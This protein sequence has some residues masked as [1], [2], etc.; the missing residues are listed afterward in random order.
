MCYCY[1]LWKLNCMSSYCLVMFCNMF[2]LLIEY[3]VI[4]M[5]LLKVKEFCKVVELLIM[6]GKKLLL[7]NCCLVFNCLCDC[8][9][10]VKLFD[11]F[12]L[13]FVN[14]LG[15]YLCVLKFGFCVGDNVLMVLVELFDCLEVDEMENV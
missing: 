14:C 8:D 13:C 6:F 7:V 1:G 2:N 3:E 9:L 5:M 10:V 15:G 11:V 12:G 4:K